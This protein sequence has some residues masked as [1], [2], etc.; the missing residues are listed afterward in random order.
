[1][2][3]QYHAEERL[4]FFIDI[5]AHVNKRG[6]F[7]YGNALVCFDG[8]HCQRCH[9]HPATVVVVDRFFFS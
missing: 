3:L 7:L 5:H 4:R 8:H 6:L 1:M 2:M 9:L